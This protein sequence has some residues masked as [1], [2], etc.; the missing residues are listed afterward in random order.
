VLAIGATRGTGLLIARLLTQAGVP[1]RA[2]AR[3][4]ARATEALGPA[5]EIMAGDITDAESLPPTIENVS[6]IVFTA[7]RRSNRPASEDSVRDTEYQGVVN[8]LRAARAVGFGGRF[9]YMTAIGAS[10]RSFAAAF[11][12]LFK[13]NTLRWR[14]RAEGEIRSAGVDYT[15]I[16]SGVLVDAPAG[17]HVIKL[18]QTPLP[19][20]LRYRIARGDVAECFVAAL[21]HPRAS[22]A[23]FEIVW[24]QRGRPEPWPQLIDRLHPDTV[25]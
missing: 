7:G 2:L 1:V 16:R 3:D 22:R 19:L 4:P 13:G 20:S 17:E 8:T 9:L 11:L 18:S 6:H 10:K 24:G 23:T 15:I 25:L 12:N 5:V 14:E 21:D